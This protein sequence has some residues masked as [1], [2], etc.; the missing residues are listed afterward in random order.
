MYSIT[1]GFSVNIVDL[2]SDCHAY[3]AIILPTEPPPQPHFQ[4][5]NLKFHTHIYCMFNI[6]TCPHILPFMLSPDSLTAPLLINTHT[7]FCVIVKITGT[8]NERKHALHLSAT[9]LINLL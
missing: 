7:C 4:F 3:S 1:L 5:F 2:N 6:S 8:T 9:G